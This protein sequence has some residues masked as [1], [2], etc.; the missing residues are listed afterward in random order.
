MKSAYLEAVGLV[1][2]LH[3]H[4]L[5]VL[6]TELEQLRISDINNVQALL[7]FNIGA[8]ELTVGELTARGYYL[9]TNVTYNLKKLVETGYVLQERSPHDRRS[10]RVR[11]SEKG[12]KLRADLDVAFDRHVTALPDEGLSAGG[13]EQLNDSLRT[14]ERFWTNALQFGVGRLVRSRAA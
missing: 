8:E 11:L 4:F 2:R 9:G 6:R 3:R 14:L 7:L 5:D 12:L 10:V 1:E 13:L